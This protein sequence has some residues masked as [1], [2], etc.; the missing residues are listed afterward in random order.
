MP[1]KSQSHYNPVAS[2]NSC[3]N[4]DYIGEHHS[5]NLSI[6]GKRFVPSPF[7]SK[8]Y[9]IYT[10]SK[11]SIRFDKLIEMGLYM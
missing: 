8:K 5:K 10:W 11:N 2:W 3:I 7:K 4:D 1:L 6:C 9:L